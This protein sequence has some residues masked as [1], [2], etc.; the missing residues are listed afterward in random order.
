LVTP[1]N[2][3]SFH[4]TTTRPRC[5]T[6]SRAIARLCY[7]RHARIF[8]EDWRTA[9]VFTAS[10]FVAPQESEQP[11]LR[12]I[13]KV[14]E[15]CQSGED[16]P[17]SCTAG[18]LPKLVSPSGEE[19]VL[20]SF[21]LQLLKQFADE[22]AMGKAVGI[23]SVPQ[24]LSVF[25]AAD[26]LNVSTSHLRSLLD[27]GKLPFV[28]LDTERRILLSD[29]KDYDR[30]RHKEFLDAISEIAQICQEAGAYD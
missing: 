9:S 3:L 18:L 7:D 5:Y 19:I 12:E 24:L 16:D 2:G 14:L 10:N 20:P 17:Q 13:E 22:S 4:T 25:E 1:S 30:N 8:S 23:V 29:L 11:A 27:T 6:G 15:G 21:V 28:R 26:M